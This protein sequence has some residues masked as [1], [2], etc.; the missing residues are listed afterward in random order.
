[1]VWV[2]DRTRSAVLFSVRQV[3][4]SEVRGR[5]TDFQA[6][7]S[8]DTEHPERS[9]VQAIVEVASVST[10][11]RLRDAHLR[12]ADFFDAKRY[13]QITFASTHIGQVGADTFWV[14]GRLTIHGVTRDVTLRG[15]FREPLATLANRNEVSFSMEAEV[16]RNDFG[17]DWSVPLDRGGVFVGKAVT[18]DIDAILLKEGAA[19]PSL[20]GTSSAK[21]PAR[22]AAS[23]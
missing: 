15:R 3:L 4:V 5:F 14:G 9:S 7:V 23:K 17:L 1:M 13:S 21:M 10:G 22:S 6:N 12:S 11:N 2:L 19:P 16:D 20:A 18:I 8:L